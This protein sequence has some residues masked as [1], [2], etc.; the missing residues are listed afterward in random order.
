[1]T[2]EIC[3]KS[4]LRATDSCY[5]EMVGEDEGIRKIVRTTYQEIIDKEMD[6]HKFCQFHSNGSELVRNPIINSLNN[7]TLPTT[8]SNGSE[9]IFL[10]SPTV[11]GENDPYASIQPVLRA[12]AVNE[13]EKSPKATAVGTKLIEYDKQTISITP[14]EKIKIPNID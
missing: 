10:G 8:K 2:I 4:G 3:L 7:N 1:M 9:A 6:F 13:K 5:E 14:P 11:L 12:K